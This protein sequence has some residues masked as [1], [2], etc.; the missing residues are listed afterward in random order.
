[1]NHTIAYK[2]GN[3]TVQFTVDISEPEL[4]PLELG[5]RVQLF[6]WWLKRTIVKVTKDIIMFKK[7]LKN[8]E[9][10]EVKIFDSLDDLMEALEN[11]DF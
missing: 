5:F 10:I 6:H 2:I 3:Q 4:K 1:M 9:S 7:M 8:P 11:E